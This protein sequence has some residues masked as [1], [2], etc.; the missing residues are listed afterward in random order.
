MSLI[1]PFDGFK[2]PM[3]APR[4]VLTQF[5]KL[6]QRRLAST[7]LGSWPISRQFCMEGIFSC[8]ENGKGRSLCYLARS[9]PERERQQLIAGC[10]GEARGREPKYRKREIYGKRSTVS[11]RV[12]CIDCSLNS[13]FIFQS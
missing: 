3:T 1:L 11:S 5:K 4:K 13:K 9:R 10:R 12:N 2:I 7:F 6:L 8:Q